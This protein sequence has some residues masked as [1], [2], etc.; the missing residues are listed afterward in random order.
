MGKFASPTR[1]HLCMYLRTYNT[2]ARKTS[3]LLKSWHT[4]VALLLLPSSG[5]RAICSSHLL[6]LSAFWH[7]NTHILFP[8]ILNPQLSALI[9][10]D[11]RGMPS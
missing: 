7:Y 11:V 4:A 6:T 5:V 10:D 2:V 3:P 8:H 1:R 9:R